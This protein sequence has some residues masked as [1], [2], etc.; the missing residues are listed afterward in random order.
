MFSQEWRSKLF[1]HRTSVA[2]SVRSAH[3]TTC[4]RWN[5]HQRKNHESLGQMFTFVMFAGFVFHKTLNQE[6]VSH[7]KKVF[8]DSASYPESPPSRSNVDF[9][10]TSEPYHE[11]HTVRIDDS[12]TDFCCADQ[13]NANK[14]IEDRIIAIPIDMADGRRCFFGAVIDGH[15]GPHVADYVQRSLPRYVQHFV[16]KHKL[17]SSDTEK[18][19][20]IMPEVYLTLDNDIC[21]IIRSRTDMLYS[22]TAKMGACSLSVLVTP[23]HAIIANA[24]DCE[25]LLGFNGPRAKGSDF[26][27]LADPHSA[28]LA[29][30]RARLVREHPGE[31]DIIRCKSSSP[32]A[33]VPKRLHEHVLHRLGILGT[34]SQPD[35]CY[36]KGRLQ[37][38]RCFGDFHLKA[39]EFAFDHETN[40][41]FVN[42]PYSFPY[43]TAFPDVFTLKLRK[44]KI[45]QKKAKFLTLCCDGVY[46]FLNH[47]QVDQAARKSN[48]DDPAKSIVRRTLI[49]ASRDNGMTLEQLKALKQKRR[50]HDDTS[51]LY[52]DLEKVNKL[53]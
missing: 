35:C 9:E 42:P 30:E 18:L 10:V 16:E 2:Q 43:I 1:S 17:S 39:E 6:P 52:F 50:H 12:M 21:Q 14:I 27:P 36:V 11:T 47:E 4:T 8:L 31:S 38:T 34:E 7:R 48:C 44:G 49:Q 46:D 26:V 15:G 41:P 53:H 45:F 40:R 3:R 5:N 25:G 20:Q 22:R 13:V 23:S 32:V 51:V 19:A 33:K 29:S 24:G 37:P 28:N